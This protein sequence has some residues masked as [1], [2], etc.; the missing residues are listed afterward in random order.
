[1]KRGPPPSPRLG[2]DVD[3]GAVIVSTLGGFAIAGA[4]LL[5]LPLLFGARP[6]VNVTCDLRDPG[7][8]RALAAA[9]IFVAL[10]FVEGWTYA[11]GAATRA[12]ACAAF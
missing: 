4:L 1:M 7:V 9:I 5:L 3:V 12:G 2:I 6:S 11:L 8:P 10:G